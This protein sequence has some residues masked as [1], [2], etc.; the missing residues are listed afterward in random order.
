MC[1]G[2]DDSISVRTTKCLSPAAF[3]EDHEKTYSKTPRSF[4]CILFDA[5]SPTLQQYCRNVQTHVSLNRIAFEASRALCIE[6][7]VSVQ[8]AFLMLLTQRTTTCLT[9][10]TLH[11]FLLPPYLMHFDVVEA[12]IRE[13]L[14]RFFL[15]TLPPSAPLVVS[16]LAEHI[17][18]RSKSS[19]PAPP[20]RRP[21]PPSPLGSLS[22]PLLS[23]PLL[24]SPQQ[25]YRHQQQ[26]Q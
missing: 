2:V 8:P 6:T 4:V 25:K 3:S 7:S 15:Q 11:L 5:L 9:Y 10:R 1:R 26:Q 19:P 20:L 12:V 16:W 13:K 14:G 21:N 22:S 18:Y 17:G 24:S 23:A